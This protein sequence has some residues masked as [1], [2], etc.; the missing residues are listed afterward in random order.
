MIERILY[1]LFTILLCIPVTN[2]TNAQRGKTMDKSTLLSKVEESI[3]SYKEQL[4]KNEGST[5]ATVASGAKTGFESAWAG[6]EKLKDGFME[7][8]TAQKTL[9]N[10][11]EHLGKLEDAIKEGDKKVSAMAVEKVEELLKEC[12][13]KYQEE[14]DK[15]NNK[16]A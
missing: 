6:L 9:E 15:Q 3:R 13:E 8:E 14:D 5:L 2:H 7:N 10:I 12:R 11:K 1:T 16:T 4:E